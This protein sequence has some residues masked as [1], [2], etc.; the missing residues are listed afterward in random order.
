MKLLPHFYQVAGTGLSHPSDATAYLLDGQHGLYLIDC[1]T[2]QGY[3][4]IVD[5]IRSLHFDPNDIKSIWA[6]HGHYD[7]VGAAAAFLRDYHIPLYLHAGDAAIVETGDPVKTTA[8]LLYGTTFPPCPVAERITPGTV[9]EDPNF[10]LEAVHTPGHTPGGV[11]YIL[12][13]GG[14]T[15]LIAGDTLHG[16]FSTQVG[17]DEDSWRQ[18]LDILCKGHYDHYVFGHC[19]PMLLSDA[20]ER[21][22]C[23]RRSFGLYYM[24]WF[25]AFHQTYKY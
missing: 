16:G 22:D 15:T 19:P 21:L 8:D 9:L 3:D 20:D 10:T 23:L 24:P 25:K 6:T 7:H 11:C 14:L 13:S 5:N 18:S 2:P 4:R 17:S 1:G 12:Q